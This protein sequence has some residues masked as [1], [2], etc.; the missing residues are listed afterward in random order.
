M[1]VTQQVDP[2]RAETDAAPQPVPRVCPKC[3]AQ[4]TTTGEFCPH[5]GAS[6]LRRRR[7]LGK[8]A[9]IVA[10]AVLSLLVLGGAAAGVVVKVNHDHKVAA[11]KKKKAAAAE[12]ARQQAA[13]RD[14]EKRL[15][16]QTQRRLRASVVK[17]LER[18]VTKD[19][20]QDVSDGL[21]D[22]P[23]LRT[24]CTPTGTSADDLNVSAATYSCLAVNKD[25]F[26][27]GTSSGYSFT[28]NVNFDDGTY[29]WH[30]GR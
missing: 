30:L 25:N 17:E 2:A 27:D 18:S 10:A 8:R 11:D 28:G 13:A 3:S 23:I 22:G 4:E 21:L 15:E 14:A 26:D 6:Y 16:D 1:S 12:A 5:C 20:Q 19:A 29:T 24:D 7:R 9:K